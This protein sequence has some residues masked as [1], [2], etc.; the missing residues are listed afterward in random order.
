MR[1]IYLDYNATTPIAPSVVDAMTP[2]LTDHYGNP[3]SAHSLGRAANEA[4]EDARVQVAGLLGCDANEVVFT[5]GGT[6][7]NNLAIKGV[8]Y[9][10]TPGSGHLVISA[11]EHPAV[12]KPAEFLKRLGYELT[13]V[14][15]DKNGY[16]H[17]S[18]IEAAL[19]PNTRL[20]SVMQA[21]NEIG[22][23][24]P[25]RQIAEICHGRGILLHTDSSQCVGKIPVMADVLDVDLLTIAG[26][27]F[28]GPKGVGALFVRDGIQLEPHNHGA[29]HE[30]GMRGGTENTPYIV[31]L[32]KAAFLAS[33]NLDEEGERMAGLRDR[34]A[35]QLKSG[36]GPDLKI[37][38]EGAQRLPNTLSVAF[39][40]VTGQ[41]VL[42]R[43]PEL[44]ASTGAACHS[45]TVK[46]SAT[47]TAIGA[48]P[49]Q[50]AG[51]IRLSLGWYTSEEEIERASSLLVDAWENLHTLSGA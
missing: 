44:C 45:G 9:A 27:K 37:H 22:T 19:R 36:V 48:T 12:S 39:P 25:I 8:M 40:H 30:N 10:G 31:A 51:T 20:V 29:D 17:P 41:D 7:S 1:Q 26:H 14:G 3:S 32:G 6:E 16:V 43:V 38:G 42:A 47:L 35:E 28:Y 4:I 2:F 5:S 34:L 21:N 46:G 24:Q 50:A 11:V 18:E 23:I 15:C 13:V 33:K 49:Q